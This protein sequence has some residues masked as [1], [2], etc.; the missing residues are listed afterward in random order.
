MKIFR[1]TTA[2]VETTLPPPP[3]KPGDVV[4][5]SGYDSKLVETLDQ[6]LPPP[7][8]VLV[9]LINADGGVKREIKE[10]IIPANL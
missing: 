2:Y 4:P 9:N 5:S 3:W 10:K 6:V 1:V 8:L 7:L